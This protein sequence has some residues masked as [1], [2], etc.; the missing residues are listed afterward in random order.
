MSTQTVNSPDKHGKISFRPP[1]TR[2]RIISSRKTNFQSLDPNFETS[3]SNNLKA[4]S[5][6]LPTASDCLTQRSPLGSYNSINQGQI[7]SSKRILGARQ[8]ENSLGLARIISPRKYEFFKEVKPPAN[9]LQF[10]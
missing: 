1:C 2:P 7:Q 6:F 9:P 3:L 4:D 10:R 5:N 8:N